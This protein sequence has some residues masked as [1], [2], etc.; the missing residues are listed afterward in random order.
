MRGVRMADGYVGQDVR[1]VWVRGLVHSPVRLD[2]RRIDFFPPSAP[3]DDHAFRCYY[4]STHKYTLNKS[5]CYVHGS[6]SC[7]S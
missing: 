2:L 3:S 5:C 7:K 6:L 4:L 1:V